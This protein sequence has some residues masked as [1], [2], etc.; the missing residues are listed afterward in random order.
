[1]LD[2]E[3]N[4]FLRENT[5]SNSRETLLQLVGLAAFLARVNS[6]K[7]RSLRLSFLFDRIDEYKCTKSSCRNE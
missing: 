5:A 3:W 4:I 6:G 2:R 7:S 1:M